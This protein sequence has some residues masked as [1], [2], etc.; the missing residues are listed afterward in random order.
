MFYQHIMF[1]QEKKKRTCFKQMHSIHCSSLLH[2]SFLLLISL[3][4]STKE[5]ALYLFL[6]QCSFWSQD[7][8][9]CSGPHLLSQLHCLVPGVMEVQGSL[10]CCRSLIRRGQSNPD[11]R[12]VGKM[13]RLVI[14]CIFFE[15]HSSLQSIDY[16]YLLPCIMQWSHIA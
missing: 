13:M 10:M 16:S 2:F 5:R 1:L 6:Q 11:E 3:C 9:L 12:E 14:R 8:W 15:P 7:L 4:P